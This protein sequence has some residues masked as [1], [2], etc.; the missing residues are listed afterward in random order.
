MSLVSIFSRS[1]SAWDGSGAI[2]RAHLRHAIEKRQFAVHYQPVMSADS[3]S[4]VALEALLR[5]QF[6]TQTVAPASF[7]PVAEESGLIIPIG[8]LAIRQ[9]CS[10]AA[11][12]HHSRYGEVQV[13]VNLS[14]VQ[15]ADARLATMVQQA[16]DDAAL[17]AK[18]LAVEV[19]ERDVRAD[20]S[21]AAAAFERLRRMRVETLLDDFGQSN[22]STSVLDALPLDGVK[23]SLE[24]AAASAQARATLLASVEA[25][26]ARGLRVTAKHVGTPGE[27]D[28]LRQLN[29]EFVQGY[30]Y[31]PAFPDQALGAPGSSD[32]GHEQS[33]A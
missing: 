31:G 13:S 2:T 14:R 1:G 28:L 19:A 20:L 27:V 33:A 23:V 18:L 32:G 26:R 3:G 5:W 25:A 10:F 17:P 24:A 6:G 30:I 29:V 4:L 22:D 8:E 12:L 9:A 15:L 11:S 16:L 7:L 21:T